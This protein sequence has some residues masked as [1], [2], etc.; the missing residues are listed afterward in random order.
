MTVKILT[1]HRR[2]ALSLIV[3]F[4]MVFGTVTPAIGAVYQSQTTEPEIMTASI[5]PFNAASFYWNLNLTPGATVEV[6]RFTWHTRQSTGSIRVWPQGYPEEARTVAATNTARRSGTGY[7]V[8]QVTLEGLTPETVYVYEIIA[9]SS[10]SAQKTFRTGGAD[11]FQFMIAGDVQIGVGHA[12]MPGV[13]PGGVQGLTND[14]IGWRNTLDVAVNAFPEM[15]FIL[16]VGDQIQT[17]SGTSAANLSNSQLRYDLLMAPPQLHNLPFAPVVGNHDNTGSN[18]ELWHQ[19]YNTPI[20]SGTG[21]TQGNFLRFGANATQFDYWFRWGNVL[22][23]VLDSNTRTWAGG[24]QP[25][26]ESAIAQ[27]ECA[28]WRVVSFHHPPYSAYRILSG[29]G[30]DAAKMQIINNWAPV[31]Q[32][33]DIDIVLNGHCHSYSRTHQMISNVAQLNQRWLDADGNI[34]HGNY[35][36]YHNAVLNPTGIVYI[37]FNSASGSGFYN[38]RNMAPRFYLSRYNQNFRR[39]FTVVDVTPVSFSVATYQVNDDGSHSMVD[40]YTIVRGGDNNVVP[41]GFE[42]PVMGGVGAANEI[43]RVAQPAAVTGVARTAPA[44]AAGW[45]LPATVRIETTVSN[46]VGGQLGTIRNRT[47]TY[48]EQTRPVNARVDWLVSESAFDP[49][50]PL[51]QTVTVSGEIILPNGVSNTAGHTAQV[52]VTIAGEPV[53]PPP[54]P[55][56]PAGMI[57]LSDFGSYYHFYGRMNAAFHAGSLDPAVFTTWPSIPTAAGFGTPASGSGLTLAHTIPTGVGAHNQMHSGSNR[58]PWTYFSRTFYVPA[59]ICLNSIGNAGGRHQVDDAMIIFINGVEVY[60]WNA[61]SSTA[62][63][64]PSQAAAPVIMGDTITWNHFAG[65][66][67]DAANRTFNINSDFN[68]RDSGYAAMMAGNL[69]DAASRTNLENALQPGVNVI[70]AVMGQNAQASSDLWFNL[71]FHI[72]YSDCECVTPVDREVLA[73]KVTAANAR[74]QATYTTASWTPFATALATAVTVLADENAT[75]EAVDAA[76]SNLRGAYNALVVYVP[77]VNFAALQAKVTAA[78][79][80]VQ[81]S[82]TPE[83]WTPFSAAL[84]T[85]VTVLANESAAQNAVDAAESNLRIAYNALV[86]YEPYEPYVPYVPTINRTALASAIYNAE[87]RVRAA[88][89]DATWNLMQRTLVQARNVYGNANATQAQ[90]DSAT[91][92]LSTT[93]G[94]LRPSAVTPPPPPIN[95]GALGNAI[96]DAEGRTQANYNP[97]TWTLMQR[98]LVQARNMYNNASAAQAQIDTAASTLNTALGNL[99]P[100]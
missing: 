7:R 22:F 71:E 42:V 5:E 94:N 11:T 4:V 12:G 95:R 35:G 68:N 66:N 58:H 40:V 72:A 87:G 93:L 47:D 73:A 36:A 13:T 23:I 55:P 77:A 69:H 19:H 98:T 100:R 28:E 90:V 50:N 67:S 86:I 99:R 21:V 29:S 75:Q 14:G 6:M 52:Q 63:G 34:H 33:N 57:I 59:H 46:N 96:A 2:K 60:R 54:P 51:Q 91:N 79:A 56:P 27:N 31:F 38:V 10:V 48:R 45:N 32:A 37:A 65:R 8:N 41:A 78:N 9:G 62:T 18:Q 30:A 20:P 89:T 53:P 70:T 76:E 15:E 74:I 1:Q 43:E 17:Q 83:S 3:A 88:Y 81:A 84:A 24:R 44:T 85:A 97:A 26:F 82:Y 25:F 39:N 92:N 61:F 16:S 64:N 49:E 80:R